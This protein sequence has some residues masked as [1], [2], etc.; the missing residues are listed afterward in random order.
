MNPKQEK[1]F[2]FSCLRY[3]RRKIGFRV[4]IH[5]TSKKPFFAFLVS[6]GAF[7]VSQRY[8]EIFKKKIFL[9]RMKGGFSRGRSPFERV[10]SSALAYQLYEIKLE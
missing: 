2:Y 7:G 3:K 8:Q 4:E 1:N 5:S 9:H 10:Q 6:L